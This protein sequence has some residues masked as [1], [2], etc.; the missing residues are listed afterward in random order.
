MI[1]RR[2]AEGTHLDIAETPETDLDRHGLE[3]DPVG[4]TEGNQIEDQR[5]KIGDQ[6]GT[7]AD[8]TNSTRDANEFHR[9]L[10]LL[11]SSRLRFE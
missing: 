9:L 11:L 5:Q 4:Q 2:G 3:G 6:R 10:R 8:R 1:S 7:E